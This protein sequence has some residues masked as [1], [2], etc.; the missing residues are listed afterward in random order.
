LAPKSYKNQQTGLFYKLQEAQ[1]DLENAPADKKEKFQRRVDKIKK[2][3]EDLREQMYN[4][5]E[6]M[7]KED[8]KGFELM[9]EKI[10]E[11]HDALD[12]ITGGKNYSESAK[13]QAR[14]DF[15]E[16]ADVVGDLFAVTDINYDSDIELEL[17]KYFKVAEDIDKLKI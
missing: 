5:F 16:A 1:E 7:Q 15:K 12:I 13:E 17:S 9:I 6:L 10:Q 8:P 11:Q 4:Q 2:Q 14:K 3:Q